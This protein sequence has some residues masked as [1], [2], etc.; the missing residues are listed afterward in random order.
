MKD[1]LSSDLQ[2]SST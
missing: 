2:L 1:H